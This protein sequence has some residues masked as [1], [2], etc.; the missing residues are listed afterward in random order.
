FA[1]PSVLCFL[2]FANSAFGQKLTSAPAVKAKTEKTVAAKVS[3]KAKLSAQ[4][5]RVP[6]AFEQNIGQ[7]DQR[8]K[9]LSRGAGYTLFLTQDEAVLALA[10]G[11]KSADVVRVKLNGASTGA[12]V[13]ALERL[14]WDNNYFIGNDPKKWRTHVANYRK[15]QF[16]DVYPGIQLVYYGNQQQ[17]EHDFV[18]SPGAD[19]KKIQME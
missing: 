6:L 1:I 19:P 8:V 3:D 14:K 2:V 10:A 13:T 18:V 7:D 15:V 16:E 12:H 9:Y 17:L 5:A 11:K 4:F